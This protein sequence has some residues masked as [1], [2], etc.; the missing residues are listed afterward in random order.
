[1]EALA[2]QFADR[3]VRS[4]FVYTREAHPGEKHPHLTSFEQKLGNA[5]EMAKVWGI[6]RAMLVDDMD[7][8]VHRAYG[9]LPNMTYVVA[10]RGTVHFRS[11]WTDAG[12]IGIILEQLC[13][14]AEG[15][16]ERRRMIPFYSEW[17]PAREVNRHKF[18]QGLLDAGGVRS[19][20]EF[21]AAMGAAR[22][23]AEAASM[24]KW[25]DAQR[26]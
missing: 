25:W 21:I 5:R 3:R 8:T 11:S 24:Q 9:K 16:R 26:R 14:E 18:L 19:V 15:R 6:E 23:P 1:M 17:L 13:V 22:G 7:G 4:I 2:K 20:E 10:R 12:I